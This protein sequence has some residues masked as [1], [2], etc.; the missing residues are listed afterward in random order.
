MPVVTP[1][2]RKKFQKIFWSVLGGAMGEKVQKNGGV[3][4]RFR[5]WV[6]TGVYPQKGEVWKSQISSA[7][8]SYNILPSF[9]KKFQGEKKLWIFFQMYSQAKNK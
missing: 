4:C 8:M 1:T 3:F 2:L 9:K 6:S 7:H 5:R